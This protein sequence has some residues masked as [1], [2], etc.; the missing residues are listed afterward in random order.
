MLH[1]P[2]REE[3]RLGFTLWLTGLSGAGKSTIAKLVADRLRKCGSRVELLDGDVIR[4]QICNGL[5][6]SRADRDENIRRIGVLCEMLS[7]HDVIVIVAAISPYRAARNQLRLMLH[8]FIEV[9]VDCPLDVLIARD[10]KGLYR[11]AIAGEIVN[12]TGI[13]DPYEAPLC[14]DVIVRTAYEAPQESACRV[15][16]VLKAR[17]L[18]SFD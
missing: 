4:T 8:P 3:G 18:V 17:G 14:P 12:F 10:T 15:L 9:Y 2:M 5:S 13:S 6:F 16:S 11:K 7:R 1:N